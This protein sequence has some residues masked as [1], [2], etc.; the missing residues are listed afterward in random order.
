VGFAKENMYW[1]DQFRQ[2]VLATDSSSNQGLVVTYK[3]KPIDVYFFSSDGGI[4]Q[5]AKDVWGTSEPYLI[6]VPDKYSLEDNL[7]PGYAHWRVQYSQSQVATWLGM[8]NVSRL[9][10]DGK[11]LAGANLKI[12]AYEQDGTKKVFTVSQFK[13]TVLLPSSWF[14]IS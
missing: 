9:L 6:N 4:T 11:T 3:G 8:P 14:S 5:N 2:D 10:V 7:N 13:T 12:I 1:G